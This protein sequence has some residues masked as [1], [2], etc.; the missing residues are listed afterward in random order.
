MPRTDKTRLASR[1]RNETANTRP[2]DIQDTPWGAEITLYAREPGLSWDDCR[3]FV[4]MRWLMKGDMRPMAHFLAHGLTPGRGVLQYFAGMLHPDWQ[5]KHPYRLEVQSVAGKRGRRDNPEMDI[6]DYLFRE[7]DYLFRE[8]VSR[9]MAEGN[10][11]EQAVVSLSQTIG[12][13][14]TRTATIRRAY[15]RLTRHTK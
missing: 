15:D 9:L 2:P 4:I 7:R 3:D 13:D 11:Y 8:N 12:G 10:T 5:D 6:R 14:E 1:M